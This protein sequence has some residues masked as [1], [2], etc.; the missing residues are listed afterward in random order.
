MKTTLDNPIIKYHAKLRATERFGIKRSIVENWAKQKASTSVFVSEVIDDNGKPGR[1]FVSNGVGL[2]ADITQDIVVT[3]VDPKT[4]GFSEINRKLSRF[5]ANEL[6]I[7][8]R[9]EA[10]E[11]RNIE[12]LRAEIEIEIGE[13]R[14]RLLKTRSLPKKLAIQGRMK[15]LE[16][17]LNELPSEE[18]AVKRKR[19]RKAIA[20]ARV[21]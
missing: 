11:L 19:V 21:I 12:R 4:Y 3:I 13:L 16:M 18:H 14:L 5:A 2:I 17:R 8:E 10:K 15:A 6:T 7:A 20:L 9:N 1:L